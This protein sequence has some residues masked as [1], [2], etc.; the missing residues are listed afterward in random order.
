MYTDARR[1]SVSGASVARFADI[2][3]LR[4]E[5][6]GFEDLPLERK[7]FIFHL[8]RAALL[9][10]DI[11]FDQNGRYGLRLR[12]LFEGIY[13]HYGGERSSEEFRAVEK[14]LFRLWF[15]SGIHHH[16][17]SEKFEPHFTESYLR[18]LL[19]EVQQSTGQLLRFRGQELER[20]LAIIFDP[21]Q[22][23]RRTVQS[24]AEDL[25][26][27]SSANFYDD[28]VTQQEAEAYYREA[29]E[30]LSERERKAPPSRT[31]RGW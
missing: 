8:S 4:Y 30:A 25:V 11:T 5:I 29:Y 22:A 18:Q 28:R 16:Y 17:G 14:Y 21:S 15:S 10:R 20:L 24:G 27:A 6:P 26:R 19:E 12:A 9:G 23:P 13:L 2:E 7:L 3:I 1:P 31:K